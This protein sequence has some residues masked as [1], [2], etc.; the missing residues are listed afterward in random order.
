MQVVE[1]WAKAFTDSDVDAIVA[2]YAPDALFLGTQSKAVVAEPS[3]IRKY[4]ENALLNNRP[5]GAKLND[6]MVLD[7][8]DSAVVVTGL[9]TVTAVRDGQ[10]VS[11]DGHITFVVA[12]RGPDWKIIH[13]HRSPLPK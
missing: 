8:S 1:R 12:K 3:G 10:P 13:F 2:L 7:A 4:F 5:R 11:A 9:D 6:H